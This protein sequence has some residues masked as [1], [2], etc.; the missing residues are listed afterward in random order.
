MSNMFSGC[1]SLQSIGVDGWDLSKVTN[2]S[3]MFSG[4]SSL[5]VLDLSGWILES[6]VNI[7]FLGQYNF[8]PTTIKLGSGFFKCPATKVNLSFIKW[9]DASVRES[10]V[11]NSYDR[12]ANGLPDLTLTLS[13][14]TKN[15][16][17]EDD[18]ATITAKGYIIA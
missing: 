5:Q 13:V 7:D 3:N 12:K 18:I 14:N 4:C 8:N 9:T 10:L 2:M 6:C 16:L 15:V 1:S 17:S 11:V